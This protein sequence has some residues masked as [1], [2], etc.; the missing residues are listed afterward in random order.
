[1]LLDQFVDEVYAVYRQI[2]AGTLEQ[3]HVAVGHVGRSLAR[4]PSLAD[5]SDTL[6]SG[7]AGAMLKAG[8]SRSTVNKTLRLVLALARFARRRHL[9]DYRPDVEKIPEKRA[10]P[11]AWTV[12]EL[13]RLLAEAGRDAVWGPTLTALLLLYYDTGLRCRDALNLPRADLAGDRLTLVERK[14]GKRRTF[15][16]HSQTTAA[17]AQ[18]SGDML[19]PYGFVTVTPLRKA[20][21]RALKAAGLPTG[22]K[23]L[24]QRIRRTAATQ[25]AASGGDATAFLGHSAAWV[26]NTFYLDRRHGRPTDVARYLPRPS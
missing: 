13:G 6:L 24:F 18:L 26:T 1:M 14:T 25:C 23:D 16:L 2:S 19:I 5:L 20:L 21:R 22:R 8:K 15:V 9:T 17:L 3:L 11:Q 7:M 12:A 4:P 10:D